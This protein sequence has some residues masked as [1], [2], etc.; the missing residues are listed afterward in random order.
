MT[1]EIE[2]RRKHVDNHRDL[3]HFLAQP[4]SDE[5]F[6]TN[7]DVVEDDQQWPPVVV[8]IK[9]L[10]IFKPDPS[11][12][13]RSVHAPINNNDQR[14]MSPQEK[15]MIKDIMSNTNATERELK[16]LFRKLRAQFESIQA[17]Q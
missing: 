2:V 11:T 8:E 6:S 16:E 14:R 10:Q 13:A 17:L 3:N 7:Y 9:P 4:S 5:R 12:P 15:T 1:D